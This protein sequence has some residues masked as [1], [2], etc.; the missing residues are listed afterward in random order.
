MRRPVNLQPALDKKVSLQTPTLGIVLMFPRHWLVIT[1][2]DFIPVLLKSELFMES[3]SGTS[4][5]LTGT[6]RG[7]VSDAEMFGIMYYHIARKKYD[8]TTTQAN[9]TGYSKLYITRLHSAII[10]L[11]Q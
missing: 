9:T 11:I 1:W 4:D 10:R 3:W 8:G 5:I 7:E 6:D 2:S